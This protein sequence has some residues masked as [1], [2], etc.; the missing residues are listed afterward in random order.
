MLSH[1]A[2]AVDREEYVLPTVLPLQCLRRCLA[3]VNEDLKLEQDAVVLHRFAPPECQ[4][5]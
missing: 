5:L 1:A 2:F 4:K 3:K